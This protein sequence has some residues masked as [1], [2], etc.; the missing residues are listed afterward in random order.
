MPRLPPFV[1]NDY[2]HFTVPSAAVESGAKI[3]DRP[4]REG[5]PSPFFEIEVSQSMDDPRHDSPDM[6]GYIGGGNERTELSW[7]AVTAFAAEEL[8]EV[9][10]NPSPGSARSVGTSS[11][12]TAAPREWGSSSR[13][14]SVPSAKSSWQKTVFAF[15]PIDEPC[16][17]G[18]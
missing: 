13:S 1:F 6:G 12:R 16:L 3:P 5:V 17:E 15:S 4:N 8:S 10:S 9:S 14:L 2:D 18:E 7:Y 11:A